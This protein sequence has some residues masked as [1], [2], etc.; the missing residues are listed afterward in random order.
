MKEKEQ[1]TTL[2]LQ[3]AEQLCRLYMEC[4]LSV[5]EETELCY[6]LQKLPYTSPCIDDARLL[7][8]ISLAAPAVVKA[9]SRRRPRRRLLWAAAAAACVAVMFSAKA[10]F[11]PA[12]AQHRCVAYIHGRM[13]TGERAEAELQKNL[14]ATEAFIQRLEAVI[15]EQ[16]ERIE[17][18][19]N[20]K[21]PSL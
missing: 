17:Y 18:I 21:N 12:P 3:E 11:T 20:H 2:T 10:F 15:A 19:L 7:M 1:A 4:R 16:N 13:Y 6:V 9:V 8:G 5:L 14:A